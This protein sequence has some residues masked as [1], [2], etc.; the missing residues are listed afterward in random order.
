MNSV[1]LYRQKI[2]G[3]IEDQ[4]ELEAINGLGV[5]LIL[6]R[7]SLRAFVD[8]RKTVIP[9]YYLWPFAAEVITDI[10]LM[11]CKAINDI[12]SSLWLRDCGA[13]SGDLKGLTPDTLNW[14]TYADMLTDPGPVVL[15]GSEK[16]CGH[17]WLTHMYAKDRSAAVATYMRLMEDSMFSDGEIYV[18]RY[19]PLRKLEI[20]DE[21]IFPN[22][23]PCSEE[24]RFF[25]LDGKVI[26]SGFYWSSYLDEMTNPEPEPSEVPDDFLKSVISRVGEVMPTLRLWVMDVARK[27]DGG[28]IVVELND[29]CS[30]GLSSINPIEYYKAISLLL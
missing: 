12:R 23:P 26:C 25:V 4:E 5:Y 16:S 14:H 6:Q 1:V 18:R 27:S 20:H 10:E 3:A 11:G 29:G 2:A 13:W 15:K 17:K 19:E 8:E 28:W 9:R 22:R 24:Y 21:N 30:S 7:S